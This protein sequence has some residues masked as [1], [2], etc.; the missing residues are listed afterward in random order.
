MAELT[1]TDLQEAQAEDD[2]LKPLWAVAGNR[3]DGYHVRGQTLYH[4]SEDD[5]GN[6]LEQVVMPVKYRRDVL[7]MAHGSSLA[8]HL[9]TKKTVK[10]V[11][12]EFFWPGLSKDVQDYCRSCEQCQKGAK[13][14]RQRAPLQPLPTIEDPFKRIAIDIVGP[15]QRTMNRAGGTAPVGQ[16]KTGPLFRTTMVMIVLFINIFL[17]LMW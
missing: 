10:R 15:L 9:G 6:D 16:A 3:E 5:W 12:K 14:N 8:A 17:P 2:S 4:K 11:L 7:A 13:A 1:P